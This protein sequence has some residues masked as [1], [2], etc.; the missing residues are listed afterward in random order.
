MPVL[1]TRQE[2]VLIE[3]RMLNNIRPLLKKT[4]WLSSWGSQP[5]MLTVNFR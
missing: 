3:I 1:A 4:G 2:A 5:V